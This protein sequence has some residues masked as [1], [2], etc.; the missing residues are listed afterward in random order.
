MWN[1]FLIFPLFSTLHCIFNLICNQRKYRAMKYWHKSHASAL[2]KP[3]SSIYLAEAKNLL[4]A[5]QQ[6]RNSVCNKIYCHNVVLPNTCTRT[7][8]NACKYCNC[9]YIFSW[10]SPVEA[11]QQLLVSMSMPAGSKLLSHI[12]RSIFI[13]CYCCCCAP[14]TIGMLSI[15]PTCHRGQP[16]V[17]RPLAELVPLPSPCAGNK[18]LGLG[19]FASSNLAVYL[20]HCHN[21]TCGY[22]IN[23]INYDNC[24]NQAGGGRRC[25]PCSSYLY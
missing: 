1:P 24:C 9:A 19:I 4:V 7:H 14:Y 11:G 3:T 12:S 2:L 23:I 6:Q 16:S 5:I 8:A 22:H 10:R 17:P 21:S 15:Q 13:C 20:Q 25:W 18:Q